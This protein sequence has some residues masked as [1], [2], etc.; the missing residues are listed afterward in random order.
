MLLEEYDSLKNLAGVKINPGPQA[1]KV[2]LADIDKLIETVMDKLDS[3]N[4]MSEMRAL[5]LQMMMDRLSKSMSMISNIMKKIS[6][7][8]KSIIQNLK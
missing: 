7:T 3:L 4:E 2:T 8:Q 5:R 1:R 6:D